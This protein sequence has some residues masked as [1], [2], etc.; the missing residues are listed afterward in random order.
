MYTP[1]SSPAKGVW[2]ESVGMRGVS[3]CPK[4]KEAASVEGEGDF[5]GVK[6]D[7]IVVELGLGVE[8]AAEDHGER[9][10]K[11]YASV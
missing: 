7:F 8:V 1:L 11:K 6:L 3:A 4:N 5:V 2:G 10:G 9:K